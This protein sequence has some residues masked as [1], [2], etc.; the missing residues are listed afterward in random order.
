MIQTREQR[1]VRALAA[2]KHTDKAWL[3]MRSRARSLPALFLRHGPLQVFVYLEGKDNKE[4]PRL[5]EVVKT[6]L[7]AISTGAAVLDKENPYKAVADQPLPDRLAEQA[8]CAEIA[9]WVMRHIEIVWQEARPRTG[10][11]P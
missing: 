2:I 6:I 7:G 9:T 8:A 4:D 3:E 10:G 1:I 11:Q 5:A